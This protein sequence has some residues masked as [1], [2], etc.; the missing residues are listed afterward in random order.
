MGRFSWPSTIDGTL[1]EYSYC[2]IWLFYI[3]Y[4]KI[5]CSEGKRDVCDLR[6][7][8]H[9]C[10]MW[11]NLLPHSRW[12]WQDEDGRMDLVAYSGSC[13]QGCVGSGNE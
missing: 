4:E 9:K 10:I 13:H 5:L 3:C 1:M 7:N 12:R 6:A 8:I 11:R 2:F